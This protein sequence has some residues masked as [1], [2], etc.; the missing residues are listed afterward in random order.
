MEYNEFKKKVLERMKTVEFPDLSI[1]E[2][3]NYLKDNEDEIK[4]WFKSS[5][6]EEIWKLEN[7]N[8]D[9]LEEKLEKFKQGY[10]DNNYVAS[11]AKSLAYLYE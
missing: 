2:I 1:K 4:E 11:C 3:V 6:N 9:N 5:K 8:A 10:Y 7:K